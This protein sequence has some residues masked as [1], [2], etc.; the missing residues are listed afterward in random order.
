MK[1]YDLAL[2][3]FV[4]GMSYL[5]MAVY[6]LC[7]NPHGRLNISSALLGISIAGWALCSIG[8]VMSQEASVALLWTKLFMASVVFVP[9][10]NLLFIHSFLSNTFNI[11][12]SKK[13]LIFSAIL[14]FFFLVSDMTPFLITGVS[15]RPGNFY[16]KDPGP[17]YYLFE[18]Y[19]F[20][21]IVCCS[22]GLLKGLQIS[23]RGSREEKQS[24][25]LFLTLVISYLA[26]G[27]SYLLAHNKVHFNIV[28]IGNY[29]AMPYSIG[30]ITVVRLGLANQRAV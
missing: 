21:V 23:A 6:L 3:Y 5:A 18:L 29:L 28:S 12:L 7:K 17:L 9:F 30:M 15:L 10:F 11:S 14:S 27:M 20:L 22:W 8:T 24:L 1:P 26:G 25:I 19:F 4:L 16:F 2:S 13:L